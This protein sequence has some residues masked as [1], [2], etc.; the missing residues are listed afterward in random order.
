MTIA[1][2]VLTRAAHQWAA[3]AERKKVTHVLQ[4]TQERE[5]RKDNANE[6]LRQCFTPEVFELL[7]NAELFVNA[8]NSFK[9]WKIS[10]KFD[11]LY[12]TSTG[13]EVKNEFDWFEKIDQNQALNMLVDSQCNLVTLERQFW[14]EIQEIKDKAPSQ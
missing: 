13:F 14:T 8:D 7:R 2:E 9:L 6:M 3:A 11:N 4:V 10:I 5:A 1:T 12:V